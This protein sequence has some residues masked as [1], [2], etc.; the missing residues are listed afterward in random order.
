MATIS[1]APKGDTNTTSAP[2]QVVIETPTDKAEVSLAIAEPKPLAV[3]SNR[4][5]ASG[6]TG[7]ITHED[8][9]V[10]RVNLVQK[11]GQLCDN[12]APG[13]FL[14]EK[15]IVIAK[16]GAAFTATALKFR[17]YY[18]EKIE[19]GTS[20]EMPIKADTAEEVRALGGSLTFGHPRY[21]QEVADI[22]LAVKAPN[23][24]GEDAKELFAYNDGTDDYGLAIYTIAASAYTSLGKRILTDAT[25][26]LKGGLHLGQYEI[27]SELKKNGTNSWYVPVGKFAGKHSAEKAEFFQSLASI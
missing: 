8:L 26:L 20:S 9:R 19:F 27:S 2:A 4:V 12:F 7:E 17:K 6:I 10:P 1:F 13:S 22:M 14:F 24:L 21:F 23:E 5:S 16:P 18:Q 11:S 25:F 15:Q 3:A